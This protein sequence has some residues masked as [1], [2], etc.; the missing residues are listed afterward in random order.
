MKKFAIPFGV[1]LLILI[2]ALALTLRVEG[3]TDTPADYCRRCCLSGED[4]CDKLYKCKC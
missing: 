3:F 4:T 1:L 2:V